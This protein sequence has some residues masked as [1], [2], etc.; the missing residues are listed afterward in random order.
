MH[1]R[2]GK[3]E[4]RELS[5]VIIKNDDIPNCQSDKGFKGTVGIGNVTLLRSLELTSTVPLQLK[6]V[7]LLT[8]PKH[9]G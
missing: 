1:S 4:M 9:F 3:R 8:L 7:C 6:K 2:V 5:F